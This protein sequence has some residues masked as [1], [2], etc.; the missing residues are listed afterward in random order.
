MQCVRFKFD[1]RHVVAEMDLISDSLL[2]KELNL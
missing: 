2:H 1:T